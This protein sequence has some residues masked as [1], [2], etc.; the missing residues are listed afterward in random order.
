MKKK[1]LAAKNILTLKGKHSKKGQSQLQSSAKKPAAQAKPPPSGK[2]QA[3]VD[4]RPLVKLPWSV[5][6]QFLHVYII[7][8][9][10]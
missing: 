3:L 6:T 10:S 1:K 7:N 5:S 2:R 4:N 9:N 8:L